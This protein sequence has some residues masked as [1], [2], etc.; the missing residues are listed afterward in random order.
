MLLRSMI[1]HYEM[2]YRYLKMHKHLLEFAGCMT[3][4]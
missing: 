1:S 3:N 2:K 4:C